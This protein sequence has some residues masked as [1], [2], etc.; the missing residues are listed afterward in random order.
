MKIWQS[1]PVF[2]PGKSHG[3]RSL[4]GYSLWGRKE[5]DTTKWLTHTHLR[6]NKKYAIES[7]L[8]GLHISCASCIGRQIFFKPLSPPGK[9]MPLENLMDWG[10]WWAT[11]HGAAKSWTRLS[12]HTFQV[13]RNHWTSQTVWH[14]YWS[15]SPKRNFFYLKTISS[16]GNQLY[17]HFLSKYWSVK[18]PVLLQH[19]L[20]F[21][22]W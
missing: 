13:A 11:V 6:K 3:Q 7:A 5:S 1:T 2:L 20:D 14:T 19:R 8:W 21:N 15:Y 12:A 17:L 4:V 18:S 9:P 22:R 16:A 10:A